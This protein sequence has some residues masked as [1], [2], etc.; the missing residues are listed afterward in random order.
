M[1]YTSPTRFRSSTQWYM[2][3]SSTLGRDITNEMIPNRRGISVGGYTEEKEALE[4][5]DRITRR[6][7]NIRGYWSGVNIFLSLQ[8]R[9]N[10]LVAISKS[11]TNALIEMFETIANTRE[12]SM[13]F[14]P[15][16][17]DEHFVADSTHIK[18]YNANNDKQHDSLF[19]QIDPTVC[20]DANF[21]AILGTAIKTMTLK[22]LIVHGYGR[23][24]PSGTVGSCSSFEF[25]DSPSPEPSLC[26]YIEFSESLNHL[27]VS[28]HGPS[29]ESQNDNCLSE[30][31]KLSPLWQAVQRNRSL[32]SLSIHMYC[33]ADEQENNEESGTVLQRAEAMWTMKS[34][35]E[36]LNGHP[37]I[38]KLKLKYRRDAH[39]KSLLVPHVTNI[40]EF[41]NLHEFKLD[42]F[43]SHVEVEQLTFPI[44]E[45]I[46]SLS[47]GHANRSANNHLE[48]L[49]LCNIGL[50]DFQAN[51]LLRYLPNTIQIL[52]LSKNAI[53]DFPMTTR[54]RNSSQLKELNLWK[55]PCLYNGKQEALLKLLQSLLMKYP[56]LVDFG[57]WD[58]WQFQTK[59]VHRNL[60][61]S[62]D[63]R[64]TTLQNLMDRIDAIADQN[65]CKARFFPQNKVLI[66][67]PSL[68]P[69]VLSKT[70]SLV[71]R[72]GVRHMPRR[73]LQE[74]SKP[75]EERQASVI[76]SILRGNITLIPCSR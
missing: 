55:N 74:S 59:I 38:R 51:E 13:A 58:K 31:S 19:L 47:K 34:L 46:A 10:E 44:D 63:A 9:E 25:Y 32:S 2:G 75:A 36:S 6:V 7:E 12:R 8:S 72:D 28:V 62:N 53:V 14:L 68:W 71:A 33:H 66:A 21:R 27:H 17:R 76:F 29:D 42:R 52:D 61:E 26:E 11:I 39:Q 30:T 67:N 45:F 56:C 20:D 16:S 5:I 22:D 70:K 64:Y 37:S 35:A 3:L 65:R 40:L 60:E 24:Y 15:S 50:K 54:N 1:M 41:S 69:S 73:L 57:P 43:A 4:K 49:G 48:V 23:F 18:A